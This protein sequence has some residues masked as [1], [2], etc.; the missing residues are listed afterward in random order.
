MIKYGLNNKKANLFLKARN[1]TQRELNDFHY[2]GLVYRI[3]FDNRCHDCHSSLLYR[4][5]GTTVNRL[6]KA[7][8]NAARLVL[9]ANC[10]T[11]RKP[12]H[13]CTR[14]RC[15]RAEAPCSTRCRSFSTICCTCYR[16]YTECQETGQCDLTG[17]SFF[18]DASVVF[19]RSPPDILLLN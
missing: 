7:R 10:R 11:E 8:K 6:R 2:E 4:A 17:R 14:R 9:T 5:P 1:N 3:A 13:V 15:R 19:N 16:Y 12:L 18:Y